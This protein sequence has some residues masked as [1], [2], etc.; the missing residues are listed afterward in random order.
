MVIVWWIFTSKLK[1]YQS[2]SHDRLEIMLWS[3]TIGNTWITKK[4]I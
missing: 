1:E 4:A 2:G 3:G